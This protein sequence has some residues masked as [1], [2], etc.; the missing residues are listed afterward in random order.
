MFAIDIDA[1]HHDDGSDSDGGFGAGAGRRRPGRTWRYVAAHRLTV[2]ADTAGE[3]EHG[4]G[5]GNNC[6]TLSPGQFGPHFHS[7]HIC[8]IDRCQKAC[9]A[10]SRSPP[11]A[12]V[13]GLPGE[14]DRRANACGKRLMRLQTWHRLRLCVVRAPSKVTSALNTIPWGFGM[15]SHRLSEPRTNQHNH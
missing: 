8:N 2:C 13:S 9:R 6:R 12:G 7:S 11:Q 4:A 3:G 14:G 5:E 10:R 1:C 15:A